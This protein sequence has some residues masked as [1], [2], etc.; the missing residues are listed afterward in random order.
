M[1]D[2]LL[3]VGS[4]RE[5]AVS[6]ESLLAIVDAQ[7]ARIVLQEA[8][9][10]L[11][12]TVGKRGDGPGEF[13]FLSSVAVADDGKLYTFDFDGH[14]ISVF[15]EDEGIYT[16]EGQFSLPK[17]VIDMVI[18]KNHLFTLSNYGSEY[19]LTKYTLDGELVNETLESSDRDYATF[20]ARFDLGGITALGDSLLAVVTPGI[21]GGR[22]YHD[23]LSVAMDFSR[24]V[25]LP[26]SPRFPADLSP[27][28][29]TDEHAEWWSA[30]WHVARVYSITDTTYGVLTYKPD[31]Q[32]VRAQRLHIYN[33]GHH[34]PSV[35]TQIPDN[36]FIAEGKNGYLYGSIDPA[37]NNETEKDTDTR[38]IRY[39][40]NK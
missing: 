31:G 9:G 17:N 32:D 24:P 13:K 39:E 29:Y 21:E 16:F 12:Q 33:V 3:P 20:A 14:E 7:N 37:N 25:G 22:F 19:L 11:K 8:N 28:D 6:D 1:P 34:K 5:L 36:V 15:S 2:S 30:S 38:I 35:T 4:V 23:D 40:L 27:Y 26:E 10:T 18:M